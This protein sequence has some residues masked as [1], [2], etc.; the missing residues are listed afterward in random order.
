MPDCPSCAHQIMSEGGFSELV[1]QASRLTT[2]MDT[3]APLPRVQRNLKQLLQAGEQL[4][5]RTAQTG[6]QDV[7]A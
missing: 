3:A 1:Q 6:A 4:W 5:A 7:K 2:D